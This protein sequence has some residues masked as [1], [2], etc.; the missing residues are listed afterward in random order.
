MIIAF[1]ASLVAAG[2][3]GIA[4]PRAA[5]QLPP[6]LAL[7]ILTVGA[8]VA[9][10]GTGIA[11]GAVVITQVGQ[12]NWVAE[13]G[14][15]S[16]SKVGHL[17]PFP[18]AAVVLAAI[19]SGIAVLSLARTL[20]KSG[21]QL[22][23]S[24]SIARRTP[25]ALV[26]LP[27]EELFAYA[28]PGW[29]GRI[30]ASTGVFR[31]LD[32][33]GRRALLAHEQAHLDQHHDLHIFVGSVT[34]AANP[35]LRRVPAAIRLACER[36]ADE[37]SA[38]AVGSRRAVA[39]AIIRVASP[40]TSGLSL[41][42]AGGTEVP[43]RV[44]ALLADRGFHGRLPLAVLSAMMVLSAIAAMWMYRGLDHIFDAAGGAS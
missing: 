4:A 8:L 40:V 14:S 41:L 43:A 16:T 5:Q 19:A 1:V 21:G 9:A 23:A 36:A 12:W 11:L 33:T 2:I 20:T 28:V 17:T 10:S 38:E 42:G 29:P 25:Q 35:L 26:V 39:V 32:G 37:R 30:V 6:R 13:T 18:P 3:F 27:D 24:W 44:R 15:W 22:L 31:V 7:W 34:A